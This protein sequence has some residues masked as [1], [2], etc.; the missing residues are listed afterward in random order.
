[1]Q[2]FDLENFLAFRYLFCQSRT[3]KNLAFFHPRIVKAQAGCVSEEP[4]F[5]IIEQHIYGI[6]LQL[7]FYFFEQDTQDRV[8]V[9][10]RPDS[11]VDI[12]QD[13]DPLQALLRFG[14]LS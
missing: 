10:I 3:E 9:S 14:Q 1:M 5:F 2:T 12:V 7:A 8:Q 6:D 11:Q 4:G 13:L